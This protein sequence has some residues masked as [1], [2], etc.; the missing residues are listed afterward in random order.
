MREGFKHFELGE[1]QVPTM[2]PILLGSR[3][4]DQDHKLEDPTSFISLVSA[5]PDWIKV[6]CFD[7][8]CSWTTVT[9]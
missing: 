6:K 1:T 8:A 3:K 7:S 4:C 5:N 2:P 9:V